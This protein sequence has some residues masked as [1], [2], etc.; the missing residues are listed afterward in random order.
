VTTFLDEAQ[1]E[2]AVCGWLLPKLL[3]SEISDSLLEQVEVA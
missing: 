2:I 1:L 3:S